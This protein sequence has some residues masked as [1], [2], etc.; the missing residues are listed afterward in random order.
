MN[1]LLDTNV[2]IDYLG[3][4]APFFSSAEQVVA[5]GFF[6]DADLWTPAQSFK[7]SFYVLEHYISSERIQRAILELTNVVHVVSLTED[8]IK[9]AARLNWPDFEDCLVSLSAE[10]SH[11]EAIITR[12]KIGFALS[13]VPSLSPDEWL[14]TQKARGIT[15]GST[16]LEE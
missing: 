11:S 14:E 4:K 15:Y 5:A 9:R 12:D 6:G 10:K 8:D 7:D 13:S 3:R 1:L 2:L 16:V